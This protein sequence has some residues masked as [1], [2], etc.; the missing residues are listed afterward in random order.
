MEDIKNS[1]TIQWVGPFHSLDEAK[2]HRK[3]AKNELYATPDCFNFYYFRGN[4]KG[5]GHKKTKFYSYFGIHKNLNGYQKRLNKSHSHYIN[6]KE[7]ENLDIWIGAL[8]NLKQHSSQLIE[9][10]ESIFIILY[11]SYLTDNEKKKKKDITS[12][13]ETICIIN[14]WYTTEEKPWNTKPESI[15]MFDDVII[16]EQDTKHPRY[17]VANKL[18]KI[19][20]T[21]L[22][23]Y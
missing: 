9:E 16:C 4:K 13:K 11:K 3:G 15:K 10:I 18:K 2:Q 12:I 6:F 17:L 20:Q 19:K 22:I 7:N 14:L 8:G 5:R 23:K 21:A 1:C